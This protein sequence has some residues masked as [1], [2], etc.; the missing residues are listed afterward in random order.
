MRLNVYM[1]PNEDG[2][3]GIAEQKHPV[4]LGLPVRME[5][6]WQADAS[7]ET[8]VASE[9]GAQMAGRCIL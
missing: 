7:C 4:R 8:G 3:H 6:K 9:D 1:Y 2:A 5:P